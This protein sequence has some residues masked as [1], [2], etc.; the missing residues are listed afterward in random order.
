MRSTSDKPGALGPADHPDHPDPSD[1]AAGA[2]PAWA[3]LAFGQPA[4][5]QPKASSAPALDKPSAQPSRFIRREA[6]GAYQAWQPGRFASASGLNDTEHL[7]APRGTERRSQHRDLPDRRGPA[8]SEPS[9]HP[10]PL[11]APG[12]VLGNAVADW[13]ARITTARQSGY[14]DGYRDGLVALE[15][16]KHSHALQLGA[17]MGQLLQAFE[18]QLLA[19]EAEM[20][21]T[22]AHS[23]VKLAQQVLMGALHTQPEAVV[24]VARQAV[25]ALMHSARQITL[26]LHPQDLPLVADGAQEL[27]GSR[28]V[29][30]RADSSV[31]RGGVHLRSDLG[32]VDARIETRWAQACAGMGVEL[33]LGNGV[34]S[35][36]PAAT[37][38]PTAAPTSP[39]LGNQ[40]EP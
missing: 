21:H 10:E 36:A 12:T 4:A 24:E 13:Q 9:D 6:L 35:P 15:G 2:A 26:H 16:F 33:A 14:A 34:A 3:P 30:L 8:R 22:V 37:A 25:S 29:Q 27:L 23:A 38:A 40:S 20:A 18:E 17:Q 1:K 31:Q 7:F 11:L 39:A 32:H 28:G 5:A 19:L